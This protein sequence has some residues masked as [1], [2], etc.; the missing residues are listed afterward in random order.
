MLKDN[1]GIEEIQAAFNYDNKF[2]LRHE[3]K[4]KFLSM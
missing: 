3:I 1:W 2:N 4:C